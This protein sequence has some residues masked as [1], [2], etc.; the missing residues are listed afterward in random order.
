MEMSF[1]ME[2]SVSSRRKQGGGSLAD[3]ATAKKPEKNSDRQSP[4]GS[5]RK[6]LS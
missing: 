5:G 2:R 1:N 3:H 4:L 6:I